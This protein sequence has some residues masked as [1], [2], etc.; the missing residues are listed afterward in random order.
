MAIG[1][2]T[3]APAYVP[4]PNTP[5]ANAQ[6]ANAGQDVDGD[7]DKSKVAEVEKTAQAQKP[8]STETLGSIVNTTA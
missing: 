8:A 7:N 1:S 3:S 4:A 2:A 5:P 6:K